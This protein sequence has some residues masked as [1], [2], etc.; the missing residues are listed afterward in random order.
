MAY[1]PHKFIRDKLLK[2][3]N[4]RKFC[5]GFL[6]EGGFFLIT[7]FSAVVVAFW[8]N[9][10]ALIKKLYLTANFLQ[11]FLLDFIV[12][13]FFVLLFIFKNKKLSKFKEIIYKGFFLIVCFWGGM[14]IFN[15]FLPVFGSILIMGVLIFLWLE[16]PS[17][18]AHDV[19]V[20]LGLA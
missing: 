5:R 16:K 19:L 20:T 11:D 15:L 4:Q 6:I 9:K 3:Q 14:T 7:S 1:K 2:T 17:I 13:T 12:I 8:L 10:L 18:W